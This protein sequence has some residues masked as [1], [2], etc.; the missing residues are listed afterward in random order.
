MAENDDDSFDALR[1]WML[2]LRWTLANGPE[3]LTITCNI[4]SGLEAMLLHIRD[5]VTSATDLA[6]LLGIPKGTVSKWAK[7]LAE[8]GKITR[9]NGAY[10]AV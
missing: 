3:G 8:A 7:K 6:E 9:T 10:I 1:D 2:T 4:H 5:G